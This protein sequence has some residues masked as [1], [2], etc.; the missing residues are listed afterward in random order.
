MTSATTDTATAG[1][2]RP[3]PAG[4]A[5]GIG[6]LPGTDPVEAMR[7]ILGELPELPHLPELPDRGAGADL[8]GR[9]ATFLA[10]LPVEIQPSGW[11]ITAR[12]GRDLRRARDLLARDLDAL[13]EL[14]GDH[15]GAFKVQV[16]GPWTLAASIELPAG[17]RVMSDHGAT[18]DLAQ[19]LA[20]GLRQHLADLAARLPSA[21]LVVQFDEPSLPAV[22]AGRV[23]TA[24]GYGTLRTIEATTAEQTLADLL[25]I[26]PAGGRVVHCCADDVPFALLRRAGA[27]ALALDAARL[28]SRHYDDLGE[29]VQDGTSLWL[30]LVP[31]TDSPISLESAR[32]VATKLWSALGFARAEL[33]ATI[34]PTPGC[35]LA[36][37]SPNYV[38]RALKVV[39]ETGQ[40]LLESPD[41]A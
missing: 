23:P 2:P 34:V 35:G 1:P 10:D 36:A 19:A 8:I 12:P 33:A 4:A 40:A 24:S 32:S 31:S 18:R 9:S 17:H 11:R 13:E 21:Q 30:G 29:L 20:E 5:T 16:A 3:W 14:A 7:L 6:S 25:A 39:R 41:E 15:R 22:L 37:A 27:D 28:N 38:R 26:A